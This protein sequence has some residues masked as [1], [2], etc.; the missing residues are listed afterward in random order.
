MVSYLTPATKHTYPHRMTVTAAVSAAVQRVAVTA[1]A[2]AI[3]LPLRAL[4]VAL[5]ALRALRNFPK[6]I[7]SRTSAHILPRPSVLIV[8]GS[9]AGLRAQRAL[10]D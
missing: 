9:F 8:G 1:L 3:L 7:S 10:S 5:R 2:A 4:G 6:R